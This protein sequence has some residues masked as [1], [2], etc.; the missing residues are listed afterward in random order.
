M[1]IKILVFTTLIAIVLSG[2]II[3][4]NKTKME[5]VKNLDLNRYLGTW[6]EIARYPHSFEKGMVGVTANYS[7]REDG[8]IKVVNQG[9]M[10]S[11]EGKFKKAE[12]KAKM[13]DPKEPGKLKV[14]FFLFFY[15][16][17]F[18]LELDT[19]DY[20]YAMIGSSSPDYFWIL[21]RTPQMKAEIYDNL[22][23]KAVKLGYKT[24]KI[25]KVLQ[26]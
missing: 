9:W 18:V 14:S 25:E 17:Y 2:S 20:Q 5:T 13:P 26:R 16:D 3:Y 11:F 10:G 8:K 1:K 6:Y 19:I 4:L 22:I 24:E 12:G 21:S 23:Q 7:L 15:G